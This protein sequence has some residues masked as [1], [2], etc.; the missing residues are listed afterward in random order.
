[1][2]QPGGAS[3][4]LYVQC[5]CAS[6]VADAQVGCQDEML[7]SANAVGTAL[8]NVRLCSCSSTGGRAGSEAA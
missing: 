2:M 4:A 5:V 8:L 6:L 7:P 3:A 1:M